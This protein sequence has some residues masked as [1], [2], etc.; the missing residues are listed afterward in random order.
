MHVLSTGTCL[1]NRLLELSSPRRSSTHKE[2]RLMKFRPALIAVALSA[3]WL[4]TAANAQTPSG[5][6]T[7]PAAAGSSRSPA[8]SQ[9]T[10]TQGAP[11][12]APTA[13]SGSATTT[14][15]SPS[16]PASA[17]ASRGP[18]DTQKSTVQGADPGS[19]PPAAPRADDPSRMAADRAACERLATGADRIAC[20]ERVDR[21]AAGP[22]PRGPSDTRPP[23]NQSAT[24]GGPPSGAT[25]TTTR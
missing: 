2:V 20:L 3:A 18:A 6:G 9:P 5:A 23:V 7:P 21:A 15:S 25:G 8:D 16:A 4:A 1:A 17:G 22:T 12:G 14:P 19:P 13:P 10:T 24:P 11:A